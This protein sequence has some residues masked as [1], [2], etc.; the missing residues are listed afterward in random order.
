MCSKCFWHP[1]CEQSKSVLGPGLLRWGNRLLCLPLA[2]LFRVPISSSELLSL[3][4]SWVTKRGKKAGRRFLAHL[5]S[6]WQ[7]FAWLH[8]PSLFWSHVP[9]RLQ[10]AWKQ[11]AC[12]EYVFK[13]SATGC[14]WRFMSR[15]GHFKTG[16]IGFPPNNCRIKN[17]PWDR[18]G[19]VQ[20]PHFLC[21]V[22]CLT[23]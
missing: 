14:L 22:S 11:S 23:K 9:Q 8:N 16:L 7:V 18:T 17:Y 12:S 15:S 4:P 2:L 1:S 3:N 21:V 5:H 19:I 10:T 6:A 20:P 13:L